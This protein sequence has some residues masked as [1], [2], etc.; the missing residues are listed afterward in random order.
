MHSKTDLKLMFL[1]MET[2]QVRTLKHC[3]LLIKMRATKSSEIIVLQRESPF[4]HNTL[5][6]LHRLYEV[7][8]GV[9]LFRTHTNLPIKKKKKKAFNCRLFF[10]QTLQYVLAVLVMFC[11]FFDSL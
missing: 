6:I 3:S 2:P 4:I 1:F 7:L 9:C 11:S 8:N 10:P 5:E